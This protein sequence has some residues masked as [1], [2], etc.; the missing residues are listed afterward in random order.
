[1]IIKQ[2]LTLWQDTVNK[3][4]KT[5]KDMNTKDILFYIFA[6]LLVAGL[7]VNSYVMDKNIR[8]L[9]EANIT[10]IKSLDKTEKMF[11]KSHIL[12]IQEIRGYKTLEKQKSKKSL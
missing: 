12:I 6:G 3:Y 11:V 9:E 8:E 7:M 10:L 5:Y 1:M 4:L 2:I